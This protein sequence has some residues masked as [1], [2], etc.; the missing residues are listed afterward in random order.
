MEFLVTPRTAPQ[1][2]MM[3]LDAWTVI[4]AQIGGIEMKTH[5]ELLKKAYEMIDKKDQEEGSEIWS[6]ENDEIAS[7]MVEFFELCSRDQG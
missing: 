1:S 7:L 2:G 3:C 4:D 5:E 6:N